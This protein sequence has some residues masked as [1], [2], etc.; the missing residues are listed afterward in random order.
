MV[1]TLFALPVLYWLFF[2]KEDEQQ[3]AEE[4]EAEQLRAPQLA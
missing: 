3:K 4:P 1:L 2:R